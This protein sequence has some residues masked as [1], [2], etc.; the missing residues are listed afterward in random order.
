MEYNQIEFMH[1]AVE[2]SRLY[3][4]QFVFFCAQNRIDQYLFRPLDSIKLT[5]LH[6]S[7]WFK[8]ANAN[9]NKMYTDN[10]VITIPVTAP[11]RSDM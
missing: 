2:Q 6:I 9:N 7:I 3:Y 10:P 4:C 8:E 11:G 1:G 5:Y